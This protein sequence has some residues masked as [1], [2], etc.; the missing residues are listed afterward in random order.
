MRRYSIPCLMMALLL[1]VV[2]GCS[3]PDAGKSPGQA[4]A[5]PATN[6]NAS[7]NKDDYPVFP[8]ADAGADPA[9]TAEQGG[10]GFTGEGWET[11]TNFDLTGDPRAVKGGI[12]REGTTDF[13]TTLRY[14]GPN[15][16]TWNQN[17]ARLV[18]ERLIELDSNSMEYV[19]SLATH[20]Q[21]SAD[22]KTYRFR[23]NPN[24]KFAD[25]KP[26]TA[27]DV[28]ATWKLHTDKTVQ[29]P[30]Q[31]AT[32]AT[33]E[34]V[35]AE[36]RYI[37]RFTSKDSSW[38]PLYNIAGLSIYPAHIIGGISGATFIK[39]WNDR[40]MPGSGPYTIKPEGVDKG[41]SITFTRRTDYWAEKNR[42]NVGLNNFDQIKDIVVRDRNLEFEMFKKG[43]LDYY[44]VNR[45]QMW[46]EDLEYDKVKQGVQQKRKIFNH[47]PQSIQGIAFNMRRA[48]YDDVRIRKA[49]RHLFNRELFIEKLMYN[50]Y[51]LMDSF[52]PFSAYENPAN[53]KLRFDPQ[54]AVQLFAEAGWKDRDSA[55][56]LLKNGKP[57]NLE[58]IYYDKAAER[59][60]TPWQEELRKIGANLNLRYVNPET[61]FKMLDDQ[62]FDMAGVAYGGG[63]PF[64]LPEQFF[65]SKQADQKAST[66]VTGFKDKRVDEIIQLYNKEFDIQKRITLL[67]ELDGIVAASHGYLLEWAAPFTRVVYANKFGQPKGY[68][69]DLG[70]YRDPPSLW[71]FDSARADQYEKALRDPSVKM[72]VGPS[73]DK[74]W[75]EARKAPVSTDP[76][77]AK[78]K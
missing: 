64:P 21:V 35:V 25:G 38:Q 73:E 62:Q 23:L 10:K 29:D 58:I 54:K 69:T 77:A 13:P 51:V 56:R 18:Y 75:L 43:D 47:K 74:F 63:G 41:K 33:F 16:S 37:V 65:D 50:Q 8:N 30:F 67:R 78:P 7:I 39:E 12:F 66:N 28:V 5:V 11:N 32:Y 44:L 14:L 42:L 48:P 76:V 57:L 9:V 53:E 22:K 60:Y 17:L 45:A 36:S 2:S 15:L 61:A 20:W 46:A 1:A 40:V 4:G 26:V 59:F 72:E 19:P 27:D 68:I 24:A 71:W 3:S 34:S 55:G 31:N 49:L 52:Y 70:D 6:N